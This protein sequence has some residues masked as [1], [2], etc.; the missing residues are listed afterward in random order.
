MTEH[1]NMQA[2]T[3]GWK[4]EIQSF[5]NTSQKLQFPTLNNG[6]SNQTEDKK[7]NQGLTQ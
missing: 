6:Q 7:G 1:Q 4:G 3:D 2:E 5:Y